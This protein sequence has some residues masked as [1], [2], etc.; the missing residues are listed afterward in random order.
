MRVSFRPTLSLGLVLVVSACAGA[1]GGPSTDRSAGVLERFSGGQRVE[2]ATHS[3]ALGAPVAQV[4]EALPGVYRELGL[5]VQQVR[6]TPPITFTTSDLRI[7][8][9]LYEG[10][11]NSAYLDC[12]TSMSGPRADTYELQI[13]VATQL[14]AAEGGGT[15]AETFVD[16]RA[17]DRYANTDPVPCHGTG[18]LEAQI[19]E[20]LRQRS[21]G[22]EGPRT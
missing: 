22:S 10:E 8:G 16:G 9:R 12:G 4:A 20:L 6:D 21:G 19:A 2:G 18:R 1:G 5:P 15:V 13:A 3:V 14:R 11:R 7:Q 17:R